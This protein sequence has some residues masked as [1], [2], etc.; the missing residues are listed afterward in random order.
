MQ[1]PRPS[2]HLRDST[3]LLRA[4]RLETPSLD[5]SLVDG[6]VSADL[7]INQF[8][9]TMSDLL[10][11]KLAAISQE[12]DTIK[13]ACSDTD[14]RVESI[15][16]ENRSL[17]ETVTTLKGTVDSQECAN[18][19]MTSVEIIQPEIISTLSKTVDAIRVHFQEKID[20]NT[21]RIEALEK[22]AT[23]RRQPH[24]LSRCCRRVSLVV[25]ATKTQKLSTAQ[26]LRPATWSQAQ[27]P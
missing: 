13:F 26:L 17:R 14:Q 1:N 15:E 11:E 23:D 25:A 4:W 21:K 6:I 2:H 19:V 20:K 24:D 8:R 3:P 27:F 10:Q 7:L 16:R 18:S 22:N 5:Y 9:S 12:L